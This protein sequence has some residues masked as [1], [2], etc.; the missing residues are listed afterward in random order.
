MIVT[1]T[2][3]PSLDRTVELTAALAVGE[4]QQAAAARED[5]GGKGINV[6]RVLAAAGDD[7][8][9]VLPLAEGDP[10]AAAAEG[11]VPL[12]AVP[13]SGRVRANLTITD[14]EG[15][16]TKLNLPGAT[17]SAAEQEA[18]IDA[19][20]AACAE[21]HP[22]WLAL[23][24]SL[25][26]GTSPS[27]YVDVIRAVRTRV[28]APPLIA[29]DTS[30][31]ALTETVA[32]GYPDLIKPNE[33]ELA[34]LVGQTLPADVPI[35]QAVNVLARDLVPHKVGAALIT[36]GGDGA[37]LVRDDVW[38]ASIPPGVQVR[39]TV[40]AGDSSLAGFLHAFS[41]GGSE[42]ELLVSAVRHGSATA[43]LPGT[44]LATPDDLPGGT[45]AVTHLSAAHTSQKGT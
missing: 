39:S 25:P 2:A 3:N 30:G 24:G 15:T 14:P 11:L 35:E 10:Y 32:H 13:V 16:T 34:E 42:Q 18:L 31:D 44:Q 6:A 9:A 20:V 36:L 23:C 29:V 7:V 28:D 27:F 43:S 38:H 33:L 41:R 4:V 22:S 37:V 21:H 12:V 17:L 26:Q 40:G 8:L 5:A 19:V 1:L 45:V